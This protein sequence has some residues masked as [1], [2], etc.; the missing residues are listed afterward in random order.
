MSESPPARGLPREPAGLDPRKQRELVARIL[1]HRD[2]GTTDLA[3]STARYPI[4]E[5]VDEEHLAREIATAFEASPMVVA[6]DSQ[7]AAPGDFVTDTLFGIPILLVR[8][9]SG[10]LNGFVNACRHRGTKLVEEVAGRNLDSLRCRS[11]GWLYDLTGKL[12][13]VPDQARAFPGLDREKRGLLPLRVESR[14]GM[15]WA[16]LGE[17]S[18]GSVA[19][20]LGPVD[21][22]LCE[23]EVASQALYRV[24]A[25]TGRFNWKLGVEAFLE[26]YHLCSLHP[27]P[28]HPELKAY[29]YA[30]QTSLVDRL[31]QHI[32]L[33]VPRKSIEHNREEPSAERRIQPHVT[34][35]YQV[36]PS[37][38][39]F[40]EKRRVTWMQFRP[41]GSGSSGVRIH[42][43][44]QHDSTQPPKYWEDSLARF[45]ATVV[46]D[47]AACESIHDG[48]RG[49]AARGPSSQR[50]VLF[51][52]NELGL[53]LF[54]ANLAEAR[55][56]SEEP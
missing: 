50:E 16:T 8:T 49:A 54:R 44:I 40:V 12:R 33:V 24:E 1:R 4:R 20:Y 52:R 3:D 43:V 41:Q 19:D 39:V 10:G 25:Y 46:E 11:H 34:I 53:Q 28:A 55:R 17:S 15:V 30:T 22:D 42:H 36:F 32:R 23:L 14:H 18:V 31:G 35:I 38:M 21:E 47:F 27:L 26:T 56:R 2:A 5:Y 29:T 9:P 51:G 6:H 45:S 13:T 48:C 37:T 7:L